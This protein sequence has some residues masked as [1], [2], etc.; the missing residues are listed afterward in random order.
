VIERIIDISD[1]P[2]HLHVRNGLLVIDREGE[3]AATVPLSEVAAVVVAH[4]RVSFT[5]SAV[6]GLAEAGSCLI[7]CDSRYLPAAMMLPMQAHFMQTERLAVQLR[8]SRPTCKRLWQ[9]IVRAKITAQGRLLEALLGS[10]AGLPALAK[11]VRSGDPENVEAQASRR[12]WPRLFADA[13]FRRDRDAG[14]QN[15]HLNYGYAV[16]RALTSRAICAVG[17]HPSIGIHHHNRYNPFCLADDLMEPFRPVVDRS[18]AKW[19]E[20]HDA[21]EPLDKEAKAALIGTLMGRL[22]AG[23][24]SRTLFDVLGRTASSLVAVLARERKALFLPEV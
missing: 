13:T 20:G 7:T 14:D 21:S 9:Q 2:A 23:G 8:A 1:N 10:D 15:R 3:D 17:L 24:E 6:S 22:S 18:V 4:P 5:Q 16:L 19:L 12:Y 11:R